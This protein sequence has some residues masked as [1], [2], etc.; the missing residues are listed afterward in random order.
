MVSLKIQS[1][2]NDRRHESGW[3]YA[4]GAAVLRHSRAATTAKG[5]QKPGAEFRPGSIL[6]FQFPE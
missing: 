6:Q 4:A 1:G 5:N 2:S 3:S